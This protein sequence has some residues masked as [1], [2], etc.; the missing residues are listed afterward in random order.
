MKNRFT[1]VLKGHIALATT[2]FPEGTTGAALDAHAR[3]SLWD[4]GCDYDHGTGHGVGSYL[5]VHEG[6]R[7]GI[8]K[9]PAA[10]AIAE[11]RHDLLQ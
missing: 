10:V 4:V 6:P 11:A 9:R 7:V 2:R 1:R 3:K 8:S 5:S